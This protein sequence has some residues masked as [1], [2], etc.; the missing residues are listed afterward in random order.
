MKREIYLLLLLVLL[1]VGCNREGEFVPEANGDATGEVM[2]Y[3][4]GNDRRLRSL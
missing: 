4:H 1:F 2:G 3:A